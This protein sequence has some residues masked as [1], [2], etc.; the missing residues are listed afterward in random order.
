MC[1][2]LPNGISIT[3]KSI[4]VYRVECLGKKKTFR[5]QSAISG[6]IAKQY[7]LPI[8]DHYDREYG[9]NEIDGG[10]LTARVWNV[11]LDRKDI[12]IETLRENMAN[13]VELDDALKIAC[14][15]LDEYFQ[16]DY[17]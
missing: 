4:T 17:C 3:A 16:K 2:N 5:K 10:R 6:W 15:E 14:A 9:E 1:D 13:G 7:M 12:F 11:W 8:F